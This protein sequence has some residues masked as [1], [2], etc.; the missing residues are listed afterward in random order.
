MKHWLLTALLANMA[1]LWIEI[2]YG[3]FD[4]PTTETFESQKQGNRETALMQ[5]PSRIPPPADDTNN[6]DE[7]RDAAPMEKQLAPQTQPAN[8]AVTEQLLLPDALLSAPAVNGTE[9]NTK[10]LASASLSTTQTPLPSVTE[11]TVSATVSENSEKSGSDL[12]S[13]TRQPKKK[14]KEDVVVKQAQTAPQPPQV[15]QQDNTLST[16]FTTGPV[17]N[18]QDL[19]A[20]IARFRPQLTEVILL[21]NP[22]KKSRNRVSYLV[23]IPASSTMEQSHA[24]AD[25]LKKSYGVEDL[26]IIRDGELKG[27]ISLGVF[28]NQ[29]N[30]ILAQQRLEQKGVKA[31]VKPRLPVG[32][33][34]TIKMRWSDQQDNAALQ[35]TDALSQNYPQFKRTASCQ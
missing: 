28:N 20:L 32:A 12:T 22:L 8:P 18:P 4:V 15:P 6:G 7:K 13:P 2:H 26:N 21:S 16:C 23:Y 29:Q 31:E 24:D 27:A 10:P 3:A 9:I 17:E 19:S 5:T 35:F 14:P 30:A 33:A 1:L 34:Y 25:I 11:K